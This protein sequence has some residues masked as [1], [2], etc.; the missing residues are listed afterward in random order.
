MIPLPVTLVLK[1][2]ALG[3]REVWVGSGAA[4]DGEGLTG[5][6]LLFV[7]VGEQS[8][9][10]GVCG[11]LLNLAVPGEFPKRLSGALWKSGGP[12]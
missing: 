12:D 11:F 10:L 2:G 9:G 1:P 7:D 5:L 3:F 8:V 6:L 4:I